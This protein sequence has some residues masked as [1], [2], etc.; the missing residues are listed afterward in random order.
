[1]IDLLVFAVTP[2]QVVRKA[3]QVAVTEEGHNLQTFRTSAELLAALEKNTTP[4]L[5]LLEL[6]ANSEELYN[7]L[8]QHVP[9][10]NLCFM[11]KLGE[12]DASSI[13]QRFSKARFL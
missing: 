13:G 2:D 9:E 12:R 3:V 1:M 6:E 7:Q 4:H 5:V 11:V 8:R 10:S